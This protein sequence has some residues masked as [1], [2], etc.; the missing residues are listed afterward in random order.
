MAVRTSCSEIIEFVSRLVNDE[1][2]EYHYDHQIQDALDRYRVEAR[3]LQLDTLPTYAEGG[4]ASYLTF[5]A[6]NKLK[7]WESDGELVDNDYTVLTPD[8]SDYWNGRWTFTTNQDRPLRITG[9]YH[10]PY[11]AAADLLE[12]RLSMIAENYDFRTSDGDTYNRSQSKEGLKELVAKYRASGGAGGQFGLS[13][14]TMMR[15]DVNIF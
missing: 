7:Y 14:S 5:T 2:H 8:T 6:P 10:D 11:N 13:V 3:Y 15:T 1:D 9:Y 4:T 12:V